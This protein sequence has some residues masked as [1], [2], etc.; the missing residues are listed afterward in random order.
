MADQGSDRRVAGAAHRLPA[1]A[2]RLAAL[3]GNIG[4]GPRD[5]RLR[6][7]VVAFLVAL[8]IAVLLVRSGWHPAL[9]VALVVPFFAAANG[10]YMGLFGA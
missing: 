7:G 1:G 8:V 9:R 3:A 6:G 5:A 10:L 2:Y 4:A